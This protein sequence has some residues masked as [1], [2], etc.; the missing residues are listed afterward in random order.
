[1]VQSYLTGFDLIITIIYC[2]IILMYSYNVQKTYVDTFAYYKY[3][4]YGM[5]ARIG[6]GLIFGFV[7]LLF[8]GGG[9][10]FY[11][12][13]GAEALVK[14]GYIKDFSA[15]IKILF[16]DLSPE[17]YL[18]DWQTGH[19]TYFKDPNSF[20]VCRFMVP[21]YIMG[22][23]SYWSTMLVMNAVLYI[24]IWNFYKML[25]SKYPR[26]Y[27]QLAIV[28][29]FFPSMV[30]WS[31]GILKD[32]WC[33]VAVYV[34]YRSTWL[35]LFKKRQIY[36]NMFYI[37]FWSY[38]VLSIRPFVFYTAF[39]AILLWI[40][41]IS[42]RKIES[43]FLRTILLPSVM[44]IMAGI[45]IV[46]V[47]SFGNLAEGKYATVDSMLE[48]AVIIQ[49]DLSRTEAYGRNTFDIGGFD[50]SISSMLS[51]APA[52]IV[53]GI[54]RPFL[55]ESRSFFMIFSGL[56][57]T[58]FI[59]FIAFIIYKSSFI[60]FFSIIYNDPFVLSC[61]VFAIMFAFFCGITVANFGALVRYKVAL[62]PFFSFVLFR[63]NA[64]INA[65][66]DKEEREFF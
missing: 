44:L 13:R 36:K 54:A 18:F 8:Y 35:V 46:G 56:E 20:A 52:A 15:F 66:K 65:E 21:F 25:C 3:F 7:Y 5:L 24:P 14:L 22:V 17:L 45:V 49:E 61:F 58:F 50:A 19:P 30:F 63:V 38:I 2:I 28:V 43:L 60:R 10:T 42:L 62:L 6:F 16:G 39:V 40:G 59:V 23:G 31:S 34:L 26:M 53:A 51:K 4:T 27:K 29:L 47:S 1:M 9:D 55:W 48:H 57:S 32:V 11:Y 41:F 33:L 37:I 64:V 12:F